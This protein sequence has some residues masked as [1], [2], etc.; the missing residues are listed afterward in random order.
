MF[1]VI[2]VE[3]IFVVINLN[4]ESVLFNIRYFSKNMIQ[5]MG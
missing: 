1:I 5:Y 4:V 3:A 2:M